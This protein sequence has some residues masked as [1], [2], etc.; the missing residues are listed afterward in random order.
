MKLFIFTSFILH[1]R[2]N[3]QEIGSLSLPPPISITLLSGKIH[4]PSMLGQTFIYKL[5]DTIRYFDGDSTIRDWLKKS[6]Q[7][8]SATWRL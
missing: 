5:K 7:N 1:F 2:E 6:K 3:L 8:G 4:S